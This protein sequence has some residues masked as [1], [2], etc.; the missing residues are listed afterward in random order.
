MKYQY[1]IEGKVIEGPGID[2]SAGYL[3]QLGIIV[4]STVFYTFIVDLSAPGFIKLSDGT[5]K[6]PPLGGSFYSKYITGT[7]LTLD[8]YISS[9]DGIAEQ[10]YG[11]P[12]W[13]KLQPPFGER[14]I[15]A[16]NGNN[17][18]QLSDM[19]EQPDSKDCWPVGSDFGCR[20]M[21]NTIYDASG[22]KSSFAFVAKILQVGFAPT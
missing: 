19:E 12:N 7:T 8:T 4:G 6:P 16:G 9:H 10:N 3:S 2:D 11:N 21:I 17:Y 22:Q 15:N 1:T 14:Y 5:I 13:L 18:L 20:A